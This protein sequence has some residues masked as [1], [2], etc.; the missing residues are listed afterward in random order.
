M[1]AVALALL[2]VSAGQVTATPI[3][4]LFNT[5][6]DGTGTPLAAGAI[7]P[8]YTLVASDDP[9]FPGPH[10]LVV[11]PPLP[12]TWTGNTATS[13]WIS[14]NSI[15]SA[16]GVGGASP[17]VAPVVGDAAGTYIYQMSFSLAGLNPALATIS[18]SWA[19]DGI[20]LIELNIG[21]PGGGYVVGTTNLVGP[22]SFHTF[23]IPAG[24]PFLPGTN[25]V[26]FVVVN[27][28]SAPPHPTGM[29]IVGLSGN[30]PGIPEP[31]TFALAAF[32]FVGL[33]AFWRRRGGNKA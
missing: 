29:Q 28:T 20:G 4:G 3:P 23:T 11:T 30:A 17:A 31:S 14:P 8:H 18:G 16:P 10:A 26:D 13:Q 2:T 1:A 19:V 9:A 6:V 25:T 32:G 7:D 22:G 5:G 24:S 15:Q 12:G 33:V 21:S 27:N